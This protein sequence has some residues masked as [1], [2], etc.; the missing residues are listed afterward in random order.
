MQPRP[1]R[2]PGYRGTDT[3]GALPIAIER[4]QKEMRRDLRSSSWPIVTL[5]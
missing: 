4:S 3:K 5:H 2:Y 1:D